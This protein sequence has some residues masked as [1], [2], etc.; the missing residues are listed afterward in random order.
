MYKSVF[1]AL[2]MM[3][4]TTTFASEICNQAV[5]KFQDAIKIYKADGNTAFMKSI[6]KNGP[7]EGDARSLS[8][9][10][11]LSQIEQFF[12]PIK[13]GA[14]LSTKALGSRSCYLIG[15]LEYADGPAF[16][17]ANYYQG[18]KGVGATSMFFKTEPESI[19]PTSFLVP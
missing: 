11:N 7:L 6:L 17:V 3:F 4:S 1:F 2:S 14:I 5:S 18:S 13:A 9:A 15:I 10:Q 16:A 8:Q 19:L 12:G